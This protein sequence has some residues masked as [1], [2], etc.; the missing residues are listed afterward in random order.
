MATICW[1][2]PGGLT[3]NTL[4]KLEK[5]IGSRWL[6]PWYLQAL[7]EDFRRQRQSGL[8][9]G[10]TFS[11]MRAERVPWQRMEMVANPGGF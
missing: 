11:R 5:A 6:C 2:S 10:V 1:G 7:L 8:P 9:T 3:S 4:G